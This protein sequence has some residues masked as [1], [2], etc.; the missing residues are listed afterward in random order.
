[1]M[2]S[3]IFNRSISFP[4]KLILVIV[5]LKLNT[6]YTNRLD[7]KTIYFKNFFHN[8]EEIN[9]K[10]LTIKETKQSVPLTIGISSVNFEINWFNKSRI[11]NPITETK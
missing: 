4:N 10:E 9:K 7:H 3:Y 1:M 6:I 2:K 5:L 11:D 8:L